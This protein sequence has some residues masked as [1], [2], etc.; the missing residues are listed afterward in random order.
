MSGHPMELAVAS[1]ANGL[2]A[3]CEMAQAIER[4]IPEAIEI[5][6][7]DVIA[8][9]ISLIHTTD[10]RQSDTAASQREAAIKATVEIMRVNLSWARKQTYR[11]YD[12]DECISSTPAGRTEFE[13]L[14]AAGPIGCARDGR[15]VVLERIGAIPPR[16]FCRRVTVDEMV[17]QTV[18]NRQAALAWGRVLSHKHS[19]RLRRTYV[20]IDL[21]G[22]GMGHLSSSFAQ[23]TKTYIR[24][25]LN[26]YPE[27]AEA[28]FIVNTPAVFRAMWAFVSPLLGAETIAKCKVCGGPTAYEPVLAKLGLKLSAPLAE[29]RASWHAAMRELI[30][31]GHAAD[32]RAPPPFLTAAERSVYACLTADH[33]RDLVP[34][35][36][37]IDSRIARTHAPSVFASASMA[38]HSSLQASSVATPVASPATDGMPTEVG[39]VDLPEKLSTGSVVLPPVPEHTRPLVA[40]QGL[41]ASLPRSAASAAAPDA[42]VRLQQGGRVTAGAAGKAD[43][44]LPIEPT[45]CDGSSGTSTVAMPTYEFSTAGARA[46]SVERNEHPELTPELGRWT[47]L[48]AVILA[49]LWL[50][51]RCS[52]PA[53]FAFVI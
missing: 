11:P 3:E 29:C 15:A 38:S 4:E 53:I 12:V 8:G 50:L 28:F 32:D 26:L 52:D 48:G 7:P 43:E 44:V 39:R 46:F 51:M 18:Y 34:P 20:I 9:F 19:A 16:E 6:P 41:H 22:L 49:V 5:M 10:K 24:E 47:A 36:G 1:V 2:D 37:G 21:K 27:G 14:Y 25:L 17:R 42:T 23:Y 33:T 45:L 40:P 30:H 31:D 35:S 13:S